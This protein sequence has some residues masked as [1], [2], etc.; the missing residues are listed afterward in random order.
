MNIF[1]LLLIGFIIYKIFNFIKENNNSLNIE[2]P[3]NFYLEKDRYLFNDIF[4]SGTNIIAVSMIYPDIKINFN[5]IEIEYLDKKSNFTKINIHEIHESSVICILE[6]SDFS[7]YFEKNKTINIIIKYNNK[8]QS[9]I[10]NNN[11]NLNK[12]NL[13][14]GTHFKNDYKLVRPWIEYYSQFGVEHFYLYYND[15]ITEDVYN[16]M[17]T[18]DQTKF[19]L[20]QW[21][22][23]MWLND[24]GWENKKEAVALPS[25]VRWK[26]SNVNLLNKNLSKNIHHSQV[27]A[28]NTIIQKYKYSSKW[29]GLFDLDEYIVCNDL[30]NLLK[31]FN[32]NSTAVVYFLNSWAYIDNTTSETFNIM[33]LKDKKIT[34]DLNNYKYGVRNKNIINPLNIINYGIHIPKKYINTSKIINSNHYFLHFYK[35]S[36]KN[37]TKD[38]IYKKD[39][40]CKIKLNLGYL[41][42]FGTNYGGW[43]IPSEIRLNKNSI[44]YS[45][46]VGEDISFDLILSDKYKCNILLI[47]PTIRAKKHFNNI[48][49][50]Y[51]NKSLI[52]ISDEYKSI[53]EN[54]KPNFKKIKFIKNGLWYKKDKLKFYKPLN[55]NHVSH[56]LINKMY[57]NEFTIVK[58]L[59]IK[60]IMKKNNHSKIDLLKL[61]IEGSEIEV[62]NNL[63]D[64]NIYP[65]YLCIEFDLSL[66]K[67]DKNNEKTNKIIERLQ[68]NKYKILMNDNM[69]ITF[70][71]FNE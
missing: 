42:K 37:R 4:I 52:N 12:Y 19:T 7:K 31:E 2:Y 24:I 21:K 36:P 59:T 11:H 23:K 40:E 35:F 43:I 53:I 20:V 60:Q 32:L 38:L 49:N 13:T 54:L 68:N 64:D 6:D 63:L 9:F 3:N 10:L 33:D 30:T 69:N 51:K 27:M 65:R 61:D 41:H 71:R 39:V 62:L 47:D 15:T 16:F 18:L 17:L 34:R 66:Q 48:I 5:E 58:T 22:Y 26:N 29:I 14:F 67:K 28:V 70:E 44:V 56:T 46:G 57:S 45:G 25:S 8:K 55:D 1:I 50:F